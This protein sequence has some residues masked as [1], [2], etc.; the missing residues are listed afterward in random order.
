MPASNGAGPAPAAPLPRMQPPS[1]LVPV[2][3]AM[4]LTGDDEDVGGVGLA[5]MHARSSPK[6]LSRPSTAEASRDVLL[7]KLYKERA[8]KA[9]LQAV[10]TNLRTDIDRLGEELETQKEMHEDLEEDYEIAQ[11]ALRE[12]TD[13]QKVAERD[14]RLQATVY[15]ARMEQQQMQNTEL[16]R[17]V[18]EAARRE[19]SSLVGTAT[20]VSPASPASPASKAPLDPEEP[21]S[22]TAASS[23]HD[24]SHVFG[25]FKQRLAKLLKM[26]CTQEL[27]SQPPRSGRTLDATPEAEL[28]A[29]AAS[30]PSDDSSMNLRVLQAELLPSQ[31]QSSVVSPGGR[32]H[33]SLP[34]LKSIALPLQG[35][36]ENVP[37]DTTMVVA[38][39]VE[40]MTS[41]SS[42]ASSSRAESAAVDAAT[43]EPPLVQDLKTGTSSSSSCVVAL[44]A[45]PS[46]QEESWQ[47]TASQ[48]LAKHG[49]ATAVLQ[50]TADILVLDS[51]LSEALPPGSPLS[52][53]SSAASQT[54]SLAE[55][56][57]DEP[58]PV[59]VS[60]FPSVRKLAPAGPQAA[61]SGMPLL[62][63]FSARDMIQAAMQD[64][65]SARSGDADAALLRSIVQD[66]LR[67]QTPPVA[68]AASP[69]PS[70]TE[71]AR[72]AVEFEARCA[73]VA[74]EARRLQRAADADRL[75]AIV[76]EELAAR[77]AAPSTSARSMPAADAALPGSMAKSAEEAARPAAVVE[78]MQQDA[79]VEAPQL[80][81]DER[82]RS[83]SSEAQQLLPGNGAETVVP[84]AAEAADVSST[85]ASARSHS[86][87]GASTP[88]QNGS[89]NS[90]ETS[91]T[92]RN[93]A[94]C[95][96]P[97][98]EVSTVEAALNEAMQQRK[99]AV[100][101]G[102][103]M[104]KKS[105]QAKILEAFIAE[106]EAVGLEDA[107]IEVA[108]QLLAAKETAK[109][110]AAVAAPELPA[111]GKPMDEEEEE[112]L[113]EAKMAPPAPS[114]PPAPDLPSATKPSSES[115]E[116][117]ELCKALP[118]D[119]META[120]NAAAEVFTLPEA[121]EM[122]AAEDLS[123]GEDA[124]P[125]QEQREGFDSEVSSEA[126]LFHD[127]AQ[128]PLDPIL[129]GEERPDT[130]ASRLTATSSSASAG[131][132]RRDDAAEEVAQAALQPISEADERPETASSAAPSLAAGSEGAE[133]SEAALQPPTSED[134]EQRPDTASSV[135]P[136]SVAAG[137][138]SAERSEVAAE[139][140]EPL[141]VASA[142]G[143]H[144]DTNSDSEDSSSDTSSES[145][146]DSES[147][148]EESEEV[149]KTESAS[150]SPKCAAPASPEAAASPETVAVA[151]VPE[152][153][154][155]THAEAV[156]LSEPL[157]D[158][159][160]E[161]APR[162]PFGPEPPSELALA[163][164]SE[165][166]TS[167][168]MSETAIW[169][170]NVLLG[171]N[172]QRQPR[173]DD[174]AVARKTAEVPSRS[175][176]R[177][178][179]AHGSRCGSQGSVAQRSAA[180]HAG[181]APGQGRTAAA[182]RGASPPPTP[183]PRKPVAPLPPDWPID[184]L[185]KNAQ[186]LLMAKQRPLL[187][188]PPSDPPPV[189]ASSL[190]KSASLPSLQASLR[191][192]GPERIY[193]GANYAA[194]A[195]MAARTMAEE[196][197]M[198]LDQ[199]REEAIAESQSSQPRVIVPG[200]PMMKDANG[201]IWVATRASSGSRPK[202]ANKLQA[203]MRKMD[204]MYGNLQQRAEVTE[205]ETS[206]ARMR[207]AAQNLRDKRNL[208]KVQS[209]PALAPGRGS[210]FPARLEA[211]A[212]MR[213]MPQR[214]W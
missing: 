179:S 33:G 51:E 201:Q 199:V 213:G 54:D 194:A 1:R 203:K 129:E 27:T 63:S 96:A 189:A 149:E 133:Q 84:C 56:F 8:A 82:P 89:S 108:R 106:A 2:V 138:E 49:D 135:A 171:R 55:S 25:E 158:E 17:Q 175:G 205:P 21:A 152:D 19:K 125:L 111:A 14:T 119:L 36:Q 75:R 142:E 211:Q 115:E 101:K 110:E 29:V 34:C 7:D 174:R 105:G 195:P 28:P 212:I 144:S 66:E 43:L 107:E 74:A 78:S 180:K 192:R 207:D 165:H 197:A 41:S 187:M 130:A 64:M 47:A 126:Q 69:S 156:T 116:A 60:Q 32:D 30:E 9:S 67:T 53:R 154:G 90:S 80:I 178:S 104:A 3:Q 200:I 40:R 35:L 45:Q 122:M 208:A 184:S 139:S 94:V 12:R 31:A 160:I 42:C 191:S 136:S 172:P 198:R 164:S 183:P 190:M 52:A 210:P 37:V 50:S 62:A 145:G 6:H 193:Q 147:D 117:E 81:T 70:F 95:A 157:E 23:A 169:T 18:F 128:F 39:D 71:T 123:A 77:A 186:H 109:L 68:A 57:D 182:A 16:A 112:E 38:T 140:P 10:A 92:V 132:E 4:D 46:A 188:Q 167:P 91:E 163:A 85:S 170:H 61:E 177:C 22:V 97:V 204:Q 159:M 209:L 155:A 127:V 59:D 118:F 185:R 24:Q 93:E 148:D 48:L 161:E 173:A 86:A 73:A 181:R 87:L 58:P 214:M 15:K 76:E 124:P 65:K 168:A 102:L 206:S 143:A 88:R 113:A 100:R 79:V 137:S 166:A 26:G 120:G 153:A 121:D 134:D 202:P 176:S 20:R 151:E 98:Q 146:S 114:T 196:A 44:Q 131:A 141:P 162:V 72:E 99:A 11:R 103:A 83:C 5:A 13:A 150:A